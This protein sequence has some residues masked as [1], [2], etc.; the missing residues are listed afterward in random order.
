MLED[1]GAVRV[2]AAGLGKLGLPWSPV[3][4]AAGHDVIGVDVDAERLEA[5]N[6]GR[7]AHR[8]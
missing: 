3:T 2:A 7:L 5:I 4:D 8:G 1:R 6:R